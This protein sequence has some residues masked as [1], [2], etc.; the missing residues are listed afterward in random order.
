MKKLTI[1]SIIIITLGGVGYYLYLND[2][3]NLNFLKKVE[4]VEDLAVMGN[5]DKIL[6]IQEI[7]EIVKTSDQIDEYSVKILFRGHF[8]KNRP[9]ILQIHQPLGDIDFQLVGYIKNEKIYKI[10]LETFGDYEGN[11][12]E[13]NVDYYIYN[14]Q[15]VCVINTGDYSFMSENLN[16]VKHYFYNGS[17]LESKITE[18]VKNSTYLQDQ[19]K[20]VS[21]YDEDYKTFLEAFSNVK[22]S[23]NI[24]KIHLDGKW[25]VKDFDW[26]MRDLGTV[27][28]EAWMGKVLEIKNNVLYFDFAS[29]TGDENYFN[30]NKDE[31]CTILNADNPEKYI[32]GLHDLV[33]KAYKTNCSEENPFRDF[34]IDQNG[35]MKIRW[36]YVYFI[37]TKDKLKT[38]VKNPEVPTP[39]KTNTTTT[40]MCG[41]KVKIVR[42]QDSPSLPPRISYIRVSDGSNIAYYGDFGAYIYPEYFNIDRKQIE[43]GYSFNETNFCKYLKN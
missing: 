21:F 10:S 31:H 38:E 2:S 5:Q 40:Y 37:L 16:K 15:L 9:D 20:L 25:L 4:V 17:L 35:E 36:D 43:Q 12:L 34:T 11:H 13:S 6:K 18:Q 7:D 41:D 8:N 30:F 24:S 33:I 39:P 19:E 23:I 14:D 26:V 1:I 3:L 28:E 42:V 29:I 22:E 32:D 27:D